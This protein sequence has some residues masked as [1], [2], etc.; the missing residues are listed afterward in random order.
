MI[1]KFD[2][3]INEAIDTNLTELLNS[4]NS[5]KKDFYEIEVN[6]SKYDDID[7]LYEDAEF[8]NKLYDKKLKKSELQSS[9]DLETFLIGDIIFFL[10]Y[11]RNTSK[12]GNPKYII[13]QYKIKDRWS[14]IRLYSVEGN[15]RNFFEKLT[16]KT[17]ELIDKDNS[18]TYQTTNSGNN[19]KLLNIE[20]KNDTY[21]ETL[22]N[23]EINNIVSSGVKIKIIN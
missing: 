4:V 11:D 16:A 8:N 5:H 1:T 20:R 19:W 3:F 13:L 12:L 7:F 10:L 14:D 15:I 18:Y 22:E 9:L 17:I 6:I 23:E 21:K 2:K